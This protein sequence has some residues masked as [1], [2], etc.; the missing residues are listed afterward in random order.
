IAGLTS[1]A[2]TAGE[3]GWFLFYAVGAAAYRVSLM[4]AI[5]LYTASK[6]FFVGIALAIG[7]VAA[8]VLW[9]AGKA[10]H[11]LARSPKLSRR[12]RRAVLAVLAASALAFVG[13][14]AIPLPYSTL[15]QG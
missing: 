1:P 5:A 15:A 9:P 2:M 10:L 14:V 12:R 6:L 7:F 11:F 8:T 3:A 4:A 13:L